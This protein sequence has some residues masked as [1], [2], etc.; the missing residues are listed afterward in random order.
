MLRRTTYFS[1]L[2][3]RSAVSLVA[4]L[5]FA[6]GFGCSSSTTDIGTDVDSGTVDTGGGTDTGI[7]PTDGGCPT[8]TELCGTTCVATA[9][10]PNNC[11]K[12]GVK[13]VDGEVCAGD[14]GCTLTCPTGSTKCDKSCF[15]LDSDPKNCGACGIACATGEACIA[16]KCS[17]SCASPLTL[18]G[19][20]CTDLTYDPDNCGTCGT[21]CTVG[22]ACVGGGCGTPD[23]T[24]DDGDTI[25]NFHEGKTSAVDTDGDGKAD[26]LD[27]DSDGDGILDKDEAGDTN[28]VTAPVDSDGDGKPDFQDTDS[29]NDGLLDKD[30]VTKYKTSPTKPDTD[31]DGYTDFEEIAAGTD[32]L[33]ATSNPGSIGGFSFDLPYKGLPRS[34]D[35]TFKPSIAKADVAFITD[36]TGSMG[37]VISNLKSQLTSISTKLS[38]KIPDTAFGVGDHRDFPVSSY[39]SPGDFPFKLHQRV[40]TVLT[41]AQAGVNK[42]VAGGGADGSESQIEGLY[43][44]AVGTGFNGKTGTPVWTPAFAPDTGFD[45]TK[46]H[47]KIGGMGFRKDAAPFFVLSTDI[48]M[49]RIEGDTDNPAP[50]GTTDQTYAA[51]NF[52]TTDTTKPHTVKQTVDAMVKIGAKL[53]GVSTSVEPS[54]GT[55]PA[56]HARPQL[57]YFALQTGSYIDAATTGTDAGKCKTGLAGAL[58]TA[59]P[60]PKGSGKLVCPLVFTAS[61]SGTGVDDAVVNAISSFTTFVTFK[62]VWL[63]ARDNA[64]TTTL[65]ESKFFIRGVPVSYGTPL[66]ATCTGKAPIISDNLNST[67]TLGSDGVFDSFDGVCPG[68]TVTFTLVAKNDL[69]PATCADQ[70]FSFRVVVIGDGKPGPGVEADSRIVT[71]RVPGDKTLCK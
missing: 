11:G 64:T 43:Q 27:D 42:Y 59:R 22:V 41:D 14:K 35:L 58:V 66:P 44:A 15:I 4:G 39:G 71:V 31:G 1:A 26:Y 70:V 54:S 25:S 52:G 46:G 8:G 24:D 32:P 47:G 36:T 20:K 57:E 68:T 21:K 2:T 40:T 45:A 17:S 63:E 49:H 65:D 29:D 19:S 12:C 5:V 18:C 56:Y 69:V 38:A 51:T 6:F 55:Y 61:S 33:S 34:Q 3:E 9:Y 23:K 28:P 53:I 10:D 50:T 13:C 48:S 16:G 62:T 30:E 7:P 67:G 37:G 60:D